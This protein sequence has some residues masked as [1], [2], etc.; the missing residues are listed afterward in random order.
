VREF[1]DSESENDVPDA[2]NQREGGHPGDEEDGAPT[3]IAGGPE[4][5]RELDD[6]SRT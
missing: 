6:S 4:P 2:A 1:T 3:V 5:E